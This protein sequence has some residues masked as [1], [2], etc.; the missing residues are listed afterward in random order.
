M[1]DSVSLLASSG[2]GPCLYLQYC[3]PPLDEDYMYA[4]CYPPVDEDYIFFFLKIFYFFILFYS[5]TTPCRGIEQGTVHTSGGH[6][7]VGGT[8][9][10]KTSQLVYVS[11]VL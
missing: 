2:W 3:Y 4:P 7:P 1:G 5:M 9:L 8:L 6:P 10:A 11:E